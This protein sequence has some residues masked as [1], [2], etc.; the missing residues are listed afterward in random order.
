[1]PGIKSKIINVLIRNRFLLQGKLHK[2]TFTMETSIENFREI[3]EKSAARYASVPKGMTIEPISI[4][5]LKT[6]WLIPAQD[7]EDGMIL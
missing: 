3:C 1:M 7:N 5:S 6:E 4:G 2:E